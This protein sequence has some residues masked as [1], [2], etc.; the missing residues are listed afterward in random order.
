MRREERGRER[1][2]VGRGGQRRRVSPA[3][4]RDNCKRSWGMRTRRWRRRQTEGS[5]ST[6]CASRA[7]VRLLLCEV[8]RRRG[9]G[10]LRGEEKGSRPPPAFP[11]P[12]P[13]TGTTTRPSPP[14]SLW[15]PGTALPTPADPKQ[16]LQ[17]FPSE[18]AFDYAERESTIFRC[19]T[20]LSLNLGPSVE[21]Q[22][23]CKLLVRF[24]IKV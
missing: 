19:N 7:S 3:T 14:P 2:V 20:Y 5:R 4:S 16:R 12:T 15:W 8:Q 1:D 18:G 24:W 22:C 9:V 6:H 13:R 10:L 17:H 21:E 23:G 11:S